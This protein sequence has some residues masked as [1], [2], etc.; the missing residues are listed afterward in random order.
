M[1][2]PVEGENWFFVDESGD[3]T[4]YDKRGNFTVGQEGCSPI[5]ILGF[6]ETTDPTSIRRAM[7]ELHDEIS[8]DPYLREVPSIAKT[9]IA[10]HAKDD[11]PEVRH[12]VFNRIVELDFKA[13][14]VVSRKVESIF[15]KRFGGKPDQFYDDLV[16][17]LFENVLHRYTKN[18]IYFAKRGSRDR[19]LPLETAIQKGIARFESK[20]NTT[21]TSQTVVFWQSPIGE[22]CLQVIDYMNWAI[23]RAFTKREMRYYRFVE[24]RVSL[25]VDLYDLVHC[26]KNWYNRR[27]PFDIKKASPL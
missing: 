15:R 11:C 25:L 17:K 16:S 22:P 20:W 27:N 26:P 21:I 13:Q 9:N 4:F 1:K 3:P 14:F 5:L 19:Q 24:D 18:R 10:F 7:A 23:Y 8:A 6:I 2:K 12:K